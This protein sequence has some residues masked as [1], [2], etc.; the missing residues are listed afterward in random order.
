MYTVILKH[1]EYELKPQVLYISGPSFQLILPPC[2][3]AFAIQ[4]DT[5]NA[6]ERYIKEKF[7]INIRGQIYLSQWNNSVN[8]E[9]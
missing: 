6:E 4:Q 7:K 8:L 3:R 5:A 1:C 9:S 2:L